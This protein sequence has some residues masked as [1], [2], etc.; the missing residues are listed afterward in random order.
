MP[1]QQSRND[2][3]DDGGAPTLRQFPS[4]TPP[5][6]EGRRWARSLEAVLAHERYSDEHGLEEQLTKRQALDGS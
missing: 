2:S 6:H 1:Q 3:R 5:P 4:G